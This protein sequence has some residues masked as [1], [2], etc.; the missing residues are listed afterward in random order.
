[1]HRI[2]LLLS[3][4]CGL[5]SLGCAAIPSNN[6]TASDSA[7]S[8]TSDE[9][10]LAIQQMRDN[11][12]RLPR[13]LVIVG[14]FLDPNLT[15]PRATAFYRSLTTRDTTLITV[16]IGPCG[17]FDECRSAVIAAVAKA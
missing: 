8:T 11:P 12:R 13:P 17:S 16:S 14:G 6:V 5:L 10:L 3:L 15:T 4:A 7:F 9:A 2:C 1:M